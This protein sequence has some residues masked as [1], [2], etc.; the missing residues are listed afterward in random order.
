MGS[1][2]NSDGQGINE[3]R[4]IEANSFVQ[5]RDAAYAPRVPNETRSGLDIAREIF[6]EAEKREEPFLYHSPETWSK[7]WLSSQEFKLVRLPLN[8]AALPCLPK[9]E[10][11]VLKK[12]HAQ[13]E[14]PIVVDYNRNQVGSSMY[15]Y[16]PQVIVIDGKHRF[17][18]ATLRGDTHIMAWVGKHALETMHGFGSGGG[19]APEA[20]TNAPGASLVAKKKMKAGSQDATLDERSSTTYSAEGEHLDKLDATEVRAGGPGSGRRPGGE[21]GYWQHHSTVGEN[22]RYHIYQGAGPRGGQWMAKEARKSGGTRERV[23]FNSK[24]EALEHVHHS[25][26]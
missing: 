6:S 3:M 13:E 16:T 8:A 21:A 23:V 22:R 15:G 17:Q 11:L 10:N 2:R 5:L 14:K 9:G 26:E 7:K 19:P 24:N 20:T 4:M 1:S 18:A 25:Q 12:I